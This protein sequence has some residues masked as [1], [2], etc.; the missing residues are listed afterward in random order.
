MPQRFPRRGFF[1]PPIPLPPVLSPRRATQLSERSPSKN[2]DVLGE[3]AYGLSQDPHLC[4]TEWST[5]G[6]T[7]PPHTANPS[8]PPQA[9]TACHPAWPQSSRNGSN[10]RPRRRP[11]V[12]ASS[13]ES[14]PRGY[15]VAGT[16]RVALCA[17]P[18]PNCPPWLKPQ[19]RAVPPAIVAHVAMGP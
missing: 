11:R 17:L 1:W 9:C 10:P 8:S 3:L 14:V 19:Q 5:E 7:Q 12:R 16:G 6:H 2:L 13:F 4:P 15:G 18:L